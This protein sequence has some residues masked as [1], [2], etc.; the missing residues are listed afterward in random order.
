MRLAEHLL[1]QLLHVVADVQVVHLLTQLAQGVAAVARLVGAV[2]GRQHLGQR[3]VLLQQALEAGDLGHQVL[4][5]GHVLRRG[6]QE[7]DRV[8]VAFLRHDAVFAQ[9]VGQNGRRHPK[10]LVLAALG[11]DARGGQHQL[12][13][14]DKVLVLGIALKGVPALAGDKVKEAQIVGHL[15]GVEGAPRAA[16]H[17]L[18]NEGADV[19]AGLQQQLAGFNAHLDA[20][21][22]HAL[23]AVAGV[24][25]GVDVQ[26]GE[27]RVERA[28]GGVHHKG[29]VQ[30][31]MVDIARLPLDMP[32]LFVD[33]RGL[34]EA[35]LLFVHRL[36]HQDPRIVLVQ[37]QQQR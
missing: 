25:A 26:G 27:Q 3:G 20:L 32:V 13:R 1:L 33:L 8:Q 28:G 36:G 19:L 34:G 9:E 29:V 6:Q 24:H 18:R 30:A 21:H 12:A 23:T 4:H 14:I 16:V 5:L 31:L 35:G 15:F 17:G 7:Q 10:G 22:P 37:L 2:D 11:V